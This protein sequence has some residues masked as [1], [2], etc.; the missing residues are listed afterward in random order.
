MHRPRCQSQC[1]N[2]FPAHSSIAFCISTAIAKASRKSSPRN[3]ALRADRACRK[4]PARAAVRARSGLRPPLR[5]PER[6]LRPAAI[7]VGLAKHLNLGRLHN[8]RIRRTALANS[9]ALFARIT[10]WLAESDSGF[11]TQGNF[12]RATTSARRSETRKRKK[13]RHPDARRPKRFALP[14]FA[15]GKF[16]PPSAGSPQSPAPPPHMP[17]SL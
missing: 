2:S 14:Q 8:I 6:T 3:T 12:T 11:T 9:S 10:P 13:V 5:V 4:S 17:L 16:P 1:P 15:P 7:E